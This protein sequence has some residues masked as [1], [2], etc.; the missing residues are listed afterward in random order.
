M[1]SIFLLAMAILFYVSTLV[2][3]FKSG[4]HPAPVEKFTAVPGQADQ[5]KKEEPPAAGSSLT[6]NFITIVQ[7]ENP[8]ASIPRAP[9]F[10]FENDSDDLPD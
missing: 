5:N 6:I 3:L 10:S 4:F 7:D 9:R 1:E 8:D 2:I